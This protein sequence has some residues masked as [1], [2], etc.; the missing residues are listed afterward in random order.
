MGSE[1]EMGKCPPQNAG[2]STQ[3]QNTPPNTHTL[4]SVNTQT[5][6]FFNSPSNACCFCW[7]CCCS[8]SCLT[9]RSAKEERILRTIFEKEEDVDTNQ[10]PQLTLEEVHTW[11]DSFERLIKSAQGRV[12]FRRFL[13]TEFSEEN[14]KFWLACEDL[15][16]ETNKTMVEQAVK[17]IYEDY[18][19]VLSPKEVSLDSSA[20]EV[21]NRNMLEPSSCTFDEAQQQIYT[22]M[23]RD[24]YP[25]Y[26]NSSMYA[27]LIQSLEQV[28]ES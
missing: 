7:C 2:N 8:C 4:G 15:K 28:N 19:S 23:Q 11:G 12:H 27:D 25:R 16:K 21:I 14:L 1:L 3:V 5:V 22:L 17:Q 20:R 9:A 13:K 26:M 18:I 24:S 10:M 6:G